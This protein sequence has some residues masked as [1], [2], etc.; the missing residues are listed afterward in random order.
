MDVDIEVYGFI[1]NVH[2]EPFSFVAVATAPLAI[3]LPPKCRFQISKKVYS[4]PLFR[5]LYNT[6]N[7][8]IYVPLVLDIATGTNDDIQWR[9]Y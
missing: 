5:V 3:Q 7:Q 4:F 2:I 6:T 1:V 8:E 9:R